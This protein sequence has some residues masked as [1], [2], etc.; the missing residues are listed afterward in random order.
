[1][2]KQKKKNKAIKDLF[3]DR[4]TSH[5]GWP[6]GHG[7]SYRDPSTPVYK[8]IANYLKSMGLVDD[9]NP[10]ARLAEGKIRKMIRNSINESFRYMQAKV[11]D[12]YVAIDNPVDIVQIVDYFD[13]PPE[14]DRHEIVYYIFVN[15]QGN[16]KRMKARH[17][18]NYYERLN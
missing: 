3:L 12:Y 5:G 4:P 18:H 16:T 17:F 6:D 7:G 2:K 10:R 15:K 9:E 13:I 11:G 8:Q 14:D 1:M